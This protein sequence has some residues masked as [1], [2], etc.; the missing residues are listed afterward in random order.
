MIL[1]V[2]L[3][4]LVDLAHASY[5]SVCRVGVAHFMVRDGARG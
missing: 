5:A 3:P 2:I 4:V 1:A